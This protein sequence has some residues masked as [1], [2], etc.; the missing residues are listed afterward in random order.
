MVWR[1]DKHCEKM[2]NRRIM[3]S[4]SGAGEGPGRPSQHRIGH[5]GIIDPVLYR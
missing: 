3:G 2:E 5:E 4:G 1:R